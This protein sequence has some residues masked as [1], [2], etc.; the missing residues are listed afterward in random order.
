M[1]HGP[2]KRSPEPQVVTPAADI[3][4]RALRD[5]FF[6]EGTIK[7]AKGGRIW[8]WMSPLIKPSAPQKDFESLPSGPT[9]VGMYGLAIL[10]AAGVHVT[11]LKTDETDL[12]PKQRNKLGK[13]RDDLNSKLEK[14]KQVVEEVNK[15]LAGT[16]AGNQ[17][18][19]SATRP[20]GAIW[21]VLSWRQ[22]PTDSIQSSHGSSLH[23]I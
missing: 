19:Q 9:K 13:N 2:N 14:V 17:S 7:P 8:A 6:N 21:K 20:I 4:E 12:D 18:G 10:Q 15:S 1:Y 22:R 5:K 3:D 16:K 11:E 23:P